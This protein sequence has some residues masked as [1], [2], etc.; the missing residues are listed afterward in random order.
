MSRVSGTEDT[1]VHDK[2]YWNIVVKPTSGFIG[3]QLNEVWHYRDLFWLLVRRDFISFY[4]QTVLGPLWF[5]LQ[6]LFTIVIYSYIFG[7]LAGISTDGI[8]RPLFYLAGITC[9]QYFAECLT[10]TSNVFMDNANVFGKVYFPRIIM[11][12]SIS[13]SNL[14]RF[15]IYLFLLLLM[16]AWYSVRGEMV[17]V[18]SY[19]LLLPVLLL[20][21]AML[22]VGAGMIISS[23][24]TKYRDLAFLVGFG[25]QLLM[26]A[27]TVV[28]PLSAAPEKFRWLV[29]LN[30]MTP[31]LEAFRKG[32][33]GVGSFSWAS[34]GTSAAIV[35]V[36]AFLGVILF[37]RAER[38]FI[39]TI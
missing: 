8:P 31:I 27:S 9:W 17:V 32:F 35:I 5:F 18:N 15:G 22:G 30:P 26:W 24:T 29:A 1:E 11:P 25:V 23:L 21:M 39:D 10:K 2:D 19:A 38:T 4:K 34:L 36:V 28:Y 14:I 3:L 37:N 16:V 13:F 7:S 12:L 20:M 33:L 6:P